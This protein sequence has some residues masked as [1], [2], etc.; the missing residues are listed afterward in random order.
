MQANLS[1]Y[2][3]FSWDTSLRYEVRHRTNFSAKL[4]SLR[5]RYSIPVRFL[6]PRG[7][8]AALVSSSRNLGSLTVTRPARYL[9]T[10]VVYPI[11]TG[12]CDAKTLVCYLISLTSY[13]TYR[14]V[15]SCTRGCPDA[16]YVAEA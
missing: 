8:F 15:E 3:P 5:Y 13:S 14:Y 7:S 6:S 4:S 12:S 1:Q 16:I 9:P 11:A 10:V 2:H